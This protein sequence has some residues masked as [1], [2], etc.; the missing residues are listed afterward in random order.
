MRSISVY[1]LTEYEVRGFKLPG[2]L[3]DLAA[4]ETPIHQ[5]QRQAATPLHW[6]QALEDVVSSN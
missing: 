3:Y 6:Y 1:L 5:I 2:D 4:F